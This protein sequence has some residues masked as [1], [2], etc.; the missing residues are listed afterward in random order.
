M[1][2]RNLHGPNLTGNHMPGTG[3]GT[4]ERTN[5]WKKQRFLSLAF[6]PKKAQNTQNMEEPTNPIN[7]IFIVRWGRK[8]T[9]NNK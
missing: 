3:S 8:K 2:A 6:I 4:W 1:H 5:E 9:K 7:A